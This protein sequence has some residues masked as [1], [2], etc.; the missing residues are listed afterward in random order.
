MSDICERAEGELALSN[1]DW[2]KLFDVIPD[3]ICILDNN[4]RII[5]INRAMSEQ[6]GKSTKECIGLTCYHAV[7]GKKSPVDTCPH[8]KTLQDGTTHAI[9]VY[10]PNLGGWCLVTTSPW[11]D[12]SGNVVGSLHIARNIT[13]RKLVEDEAHEEKNKALQYLDIAGV[14]LCALDAKGTVILI[15]PRGCEILGYAPDDIVGKN[16]FDHFLPERLISPVKDIFSSL[17]SGEISPV[18]YYENSVR[19]NK[20]EERIVAFHNTVMRDKDGHISGVLFSGEDITE[21]LTAAEVLARSEKKYR[22]V[23]DNTYD[24]EFWLDPDDHFIYTSPSCKKITGYPAEDFENASM[25]SRIVHPE[26]VHIFAAHRHVSKDLRESE[27]IEFRIVH[28][29]GSIRWIGHCCQPVC[30]EQGTF[31]GTRGSNRDIT[32]RKTMETEREC[33]VSELRSSLEKVKQLS[34]LLPICASCKMIRDDKGSWKQIESYIHEH[35]EAQFSHGLCPTCAK[36][37]F[38]T[39]YK[40]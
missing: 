31:I 7:H 16:W 9:E 30:D 26:D 24:W 18:E 8:T 13:E 23:A 19:T 14:M 34:G 36:K 29:D 15:N 10:E 5:L 25:F 21:R 22:V 37:L 3:A 32:L 6:L 1:E 33:L 4:Y 11:T 35:S 38:P 39:Y 28:S 2:N 40:E 12:A 27:E 17:M 20:G